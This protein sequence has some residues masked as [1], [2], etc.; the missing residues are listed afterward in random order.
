LRLPDE[1]ARLFDRELLDDEP[2][3]LRVAGLRRSAA[4]IS[5]FA[6]ALVRVGM[7]RAR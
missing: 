3:R 4:G 6:T 7:S 2:E 5:V 1:E